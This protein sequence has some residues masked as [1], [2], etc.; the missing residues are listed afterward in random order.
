MVEWTLNL[1]EACLQVLDGRFVA[2][3]G[4]PSDGMSGALSS[5]EGK[6]TE[7][8]LVLAERSL[9]LIKVLPSTASLPLPLLIPVRTPAR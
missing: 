1:G 2:L 9:F 6:I 7:Q 3:G 5:S 8:I 4:G